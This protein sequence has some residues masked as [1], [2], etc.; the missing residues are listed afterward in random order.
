MQRLIGVKEIIEALL[1]GDPR[2]EQDVIILVQTEPLLDDIRGLDMDAVD[3]VRDQ[4]GVTAVCF[5]KVV[6]Y[7]LGENDHLIGVLSR[8]LLTEQDIF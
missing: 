6:P 7:V 4:Q 2:Q 8:H 5:F 1:R 3:A